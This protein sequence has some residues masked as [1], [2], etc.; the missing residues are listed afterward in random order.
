MKVFL[1]GQ[2]EPWC[3]RGE[4]LHVARQKFGTGVNFFRNHVSSIPSNYQLD[5]GQK[6]MQ[7]GLKNGNFVIQNEFLCPF[8]SV[9]YIVLLKIPVITTQTRALS[10]GRC[11]VQILMC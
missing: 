9:N 5:S 2:Q 1:E 4:L 11:L 7:D 3:K 8:G 6:S 10:Q